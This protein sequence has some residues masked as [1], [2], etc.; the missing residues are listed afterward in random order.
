MVTESERGLH[1]DWSWQW[2]AAASSASVPMQHP[3]WWS[4]RA[5]QPVLP[6]GRTPPAVPC[7]APQPGGRVPPYSCS[8]CLGH[9]GR[10]GSPGDMLVVG[11]LAL[12]PHGTCGILQGHVPHSAERAGTGPLGQPFPVPLAPSACFW[13]RSVQGEDPGSWALP[14]LPQSL[15]LHFPFI[16]SARHKLALS[17]GS[18]LTPAQVPLLEPRGQLERWGGFQAPPCHLSPILEV[19]ST[20]C[21]GQHPSAGHCPALSSCQK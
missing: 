11:A 2:W 8:V 21:C 7:D 10:T 9:H 6:R 20:G 3:G 12:P 1:G 19:P 18:G 5:R 16:D 14:P 4:G 17:T 15:W 13:V